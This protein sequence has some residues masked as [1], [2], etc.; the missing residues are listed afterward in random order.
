MSHIALRQAGLVIEDGVLATPQLQALR[1][2]LA[3]TEFRGVHAQKWD[4]AWRLWDGNPQ[5]GTSVYFDPDRRFGWQG[6]HHP[7]ATPLDTL[8][9]QVRRAALVH[10][11]VCGLEGVDWVGL[12]LCP[13]LYPP[14]SAL[15]MHQDAQQYSGAFTFFVH[16]RWSLHWGGELMAYPPLGEWP[17][18][19][20]E[21]AGDTLA[22]LSGHDT[23]LSDDGEGELDGPG[24]ATAI[25]P[26]PNRLVLI[27]PDRPHR[28]ARVDPLAGAH[29][30]ASLSG[31][32]LREP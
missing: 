30:R 18:T 5:R 10:P 29:V 32:F 7:T 28:I 9:E 17:A 31:F 4:R 8:I 15:S 19:G 1:E 24:F 3:A 13:W 25:A 22:G 21:R 14:G 2:Q 23:C 11:D 6:A 12:Y 26:R 27:G 16:A 20:R